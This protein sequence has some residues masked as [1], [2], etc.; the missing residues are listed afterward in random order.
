MKKIVIFA[1]GSGSNA[2]NII[3]FFKE[4]S[5]VEVSLILSNNKNA[6]VLQ[7]AKNL[8]IP[9]VSFTRDEFNK[10]ES[11][12][13]KLLDMK[14]DLIVLA[15]FMWL[16]PKYLLNKFSGRIINIHPALLPKYGGKGMYGMH[17]HNAIIENKEKKSGITIHYVNERYD[18]GEI[19]FQAEVEI[20]TNDT[21]ETLAEKVH[22]LEYIHYPVII[23]N[24]LK[25]LP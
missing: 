2:Q 5:E 19:I 9:A 20:D 3:E 21:A 1:S 18:E 15:G 11:V 17:V 16:I 10:S 14:I 8:G 25:G 24:Y 23:E 12:L 4:S 22:K 7:R 13:Q 6:F